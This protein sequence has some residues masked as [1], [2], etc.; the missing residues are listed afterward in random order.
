[1]NEI[2]WRIRGVAVWSIVETDY[3]GRL[4]ATWL[5]PGWYRRTIADDGEITFHPMQRW[6]LVRHRILWGFG[7]GLVDAR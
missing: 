6:R 3:L 2:T 1:M 7:R 5:P 4:S